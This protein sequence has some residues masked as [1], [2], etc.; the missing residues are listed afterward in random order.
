M[1]SI[2]GTVIKGKQ[3]GKDLG[4]PTAN[5]PLTQKIP[6]GIYISR[7]TVKDMTYPALT[8]IGSAKTFQETD[9]Q[10]ETYIL[11]FDEDIYNLSVSIQL[12]KKIRDNM[13]FS[14]AEELIIQMEED[15]KVARAYFEK[16]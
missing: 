14:S 8:F 11:D 13:Q 3:R 6:E 16:Q 5:V 12:L 1:D 7:I 10:A 2:L 15:T 9:Y 4:F